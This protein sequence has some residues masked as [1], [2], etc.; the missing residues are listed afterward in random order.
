MRN[1]SAVLC[2][3]VSSARVLISDVAV[4]ES[5][6]LA[7]LYM[8]HTAEGS[9]AAHNSPDPLTANLKSSNDGAYFK[10]IAQQNGSFSVTM[11]VPKLFCAEKLINPP[12]ISDRLLAGSP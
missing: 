2:S 11:P 7:D 4:R 3:I 5:P 9:D 6:G 8:L 10:V 12:L 1:P